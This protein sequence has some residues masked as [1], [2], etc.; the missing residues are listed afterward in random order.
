MV[1]AVLGVCLFCWMPF[2]LSTVMALIMDTPQTPLF[3]GISYFITILSYAN[4]CFNPSCTP[5]W[6]TAS[7]GAFMDCRLTP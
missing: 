5:F 3:I 7:R 6:M 2:H 1:V 4:S